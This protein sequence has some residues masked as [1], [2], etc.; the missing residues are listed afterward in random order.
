[1]LSTYLSYIFFVFCFLGILV[2]SYWSIESIKAVAEKFRLSDTFVGAVFLSVGTSF[3]E[4][5]NSI[6]SG[7]LDKGSNN[8]V[9]SAY[10]FY[11]V[12]GANIWQVVFLSA[13]ISIV[14]LHLSRKRDPGIQEIDSIF[15]H[16]SIVSWN[17]I[18]VETVLLFVFV[19][20]P[21]LISPFLFK[22]FNMINLIFLFIWFWYL[23]WTYNIEQTERDLEKSNYFRNWNKFSLVGITLVLWLLFGGFAYGN[24]YLAS[25]FKVSGST[26]FGVLLSFITSSPEF[27]VL[28]FLFKKKEYRIAVGGFFGS[29]LFNLT[30]PTYT[31][32]FSSNPIFG[33]NL[34]ISSNE[35]NTGHSITNNQLQLWLACNFILLVILL[36]SF[37]RINRFKTVLT[38]ING[39]FIVGIYMLFNVFLQFFLDS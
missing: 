24:F 32:F 31:N 38:T 7:F 10:S 26:A 29:S 15:W 22:G 4:F 39:L 9:Y 19:S 35:T 8:P 17:L 37:L 16:D 34:N 11:N 36:I 5:I 12:T 18:F 30:L 33:K 13:L 14:S 23:R 21:N 25:T 1:M 6:V 28:Y 20:W 27:S 2:T 3:P